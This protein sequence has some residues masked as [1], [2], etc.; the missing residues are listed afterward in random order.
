MATTFRGGSSLI[1]GERNGAAA[2]AVP[3]GQ[4]HGAQGKQP[5]A[6]EGTGGSWGL[7]VAAYFS[8]SVALTWCVA[9][10]FVRRRL[11]LRV[12]RCVTGLPEHFDR[13]DD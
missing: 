2:R 11:F 6:R 3:V 10:Q 4:L 7:F 5:W 1:S 8:S 13:R 12:K 9:V